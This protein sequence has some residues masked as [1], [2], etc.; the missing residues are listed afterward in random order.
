MTA[1]ETP[2][3]SLVPTAWGGAQPRDSTSPGGHGRAV[4]VQ[5]AASVTRRG[6]PW[7]FPVLPWGIVLAWRGVARHGAVPAALSGVRGGLR[8]P[9]STPR[10][11][12]VPAVPCGRRSWR[13]HGTGTAWCPSGSPGGRG[14]WSGQRRLGRSGD[15]HRASPLGGGGHVFRDPHPTP[16]P[17]AQP[18][19]AAWGCWVGAR[20]RG[21]LCARGN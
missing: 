12:A 11:G 17:P 2:K 1:D 6:H 19:G 10:P 9:H 18:Q 7:C 8:L 16:N 4:G 15:R 21:A 5:K 13:R 3:P 14:G 20:P